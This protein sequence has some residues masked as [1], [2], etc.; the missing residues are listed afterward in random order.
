[1]VLSLLLRECFGTFED[2]LEGCGD[3]LEEVDEG[4][5]FE[6]DILAKNMIDNAKLN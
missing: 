3:G 2:D 5:I 1:M 6:V 4:G